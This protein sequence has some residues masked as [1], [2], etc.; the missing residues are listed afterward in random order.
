M[1]TSGTSASKTQATIC[2]LSYLPQA[3]VEWNYQC[4]QQLQAASLFTCHMHPKHLP[5]HYM[6]EPEAS[7]FNAASFK[8]ADRGHWLGKH[9]IP[10]TKMKGNKSQSKSAR[11]NIA[12]RFLELDWVTNILNGKGI[13]IGMPEDAKWPQGGPS[14]RGDRLVEQKMKN[15]RE[16]IRGKPATC[17]SSTRERGLAT[18]PS[19]ALDDAGRGDRERT[20]GGFVHRGGVSYGGGQMV[21]L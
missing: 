3:N 15:T 8:S 9:P 5:T 2:L 12:K 16:M 6:P 7:T 4:K 14:G 17:E 20:S 13:L 1:S 19:R 18:D 11:D 21:L 10:T